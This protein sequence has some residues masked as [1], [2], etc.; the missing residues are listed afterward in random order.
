M[1]RHTSGYSRDRFLFLWCSLSV[2][3]P[4]SIY[5]HSSKIIFK[6][7]LNYY[8]KTAHKTAWQNT[9]GLVSCCFVVPFKN[10]WYSLEPFTWWSCD[11]PNRA[12]DYLPLNHPGLIC[13]EHLPTTGAPLRAG[14]HDF[15]LFCILTLMI[16]TIHE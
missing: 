13:F 8:N 10:Q 5:T 11:L 9:N 15:R 7:I 3:V 6:K 4:R 12:T 2:A 14:L 1:A 16:H